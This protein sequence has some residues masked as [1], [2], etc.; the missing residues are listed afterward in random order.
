[1]Q[2]GALGWRIGQLG[3]L[4]QRRP[5]LVEIARA[6]VDARQRHERAH[7]RR[8]AL[9]DALEN[10][11][12]RLR[13]LSF[14]SQT[15]A[16][17]TKSAISPAVSPFCARRLACSVKTS[18][19]IVE[20]LGLLEELEHL[21][22]RFRLV[23]LQLQDLV[24]VADR[25]VGRLVLVDGQG[26]QPLVDGDLLR[27]AT[28][29]LE[30]A[31]QH[32]LHRREVAPPPLQL[33]ERVERRPRVGR[34][35][36]EVAVGLDRLIEVADLLRPQR[37]D[38]RLEPRSARPALPRR[39][40]VCCQ[41]S[42]PIRPSPP[43]VEAR[44]RVERAVV[45]VVDVEHLPPACDRARASPS[46]ALR[47]RAPPRRACRLL[48]GHVARAP[49]ARAERTLG[50]L[51]RVAPRA[52][53][54]VERLER[55]A[56]ARASTSSTARKR[57]LG[58]LRPA[59]LPEPRRA[60]AELARARRDAAPPSTRSKAR[61]PVAAAHRAAAPSRS[62]SSASRGS[63]GR[64]APRAH[65]VERAADRAAAARSARR[66][67]SSS[68]TC[69]DALVMPRRTSASCDALLVVAVV[70]VERLEQSSAASAC[71]CDASSSSRPARVAGVRGSRSSAS[72]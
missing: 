1:M 52:I 13:I 72:R 51:R 67:R 28:D 32:L 57:A 15:S 22:V 49:A 34:V 12:R 2:L 29:G 6:F 39:A 16:A 7:V 69:A 30:L 59:A 25:V 68:A 36:E 70:L 61:P 8:I 41:Q 20:A 47:Q 44:Q 4:L 50:Q 24:Q 63:S 56:V 38:A 3:R 42:R 45:G 40:P 53:D 9:E 64:A 19:E 37:R 55:L 54:A 21:R 10:L 23:G 48:R 62:T 65:R 27:P 14:S 17:R 66:C 31:H 18:I 5:R 43:L 35:V 46:V 60:Q 11:R 71:A 26:H 33:L 58:P